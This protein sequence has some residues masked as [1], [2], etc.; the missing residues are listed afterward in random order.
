MSLNKFKEHGKFLM[1]ALDHRGSFKKLMNPKD[2]DEVAD[3]E[4]IDLKKEII[5]SLQDQFSGLLI[6]V[7]DGLPAYT[8]K[9]SFSSSKQSFSSSKSKPFLLP[10]EKSG[11][12]EEE[13]ER[14]TELQRTVAELLS[15]GA[16][17]G[18]LLL[19]FN[20]SLKSA[21]KQLEIAKKAL[22]DANAHGF[23]FFLEPVTYTKDGKTHTQDKELV[24]GTVKTLK[25]AG[26]KPDVFKIEYPGNID[27]CM[28]VTKILG[29]TPW[30]LLAYPDSFEKFK[31]HLDSAIKGGAQGF[32]AGRAIW[33][34][35]CTLK[36][37]EKEKFLKETMPERFR[38]IV[39]ITKKH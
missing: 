11:Y 39:E 29:D 17:G 19:Y 35:A 31:T 5:E 20:P 15:L 13:G 37:K 23:T 30:I 24:L 10:L 32:L 3:Q 16:D 8:N 4:V 27:G 1:L 25:E 2:P 21:Q 36:G 34:E 26:V 18:K 7:E 12:K 22:D 28:E 9:Q 14:I 6:D 38:Q 33:Q